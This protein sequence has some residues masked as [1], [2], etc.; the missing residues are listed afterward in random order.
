MHRVARL[1]LAAL[2]AQTA[3]GFILPQR[4]FSGGLQLGA[5]L[6]SQTAARDLGVQ[7]FDHDSTIRTAYDEWRG[8]FGKGAFD[9]ERFEKFKQN[10]KTLTVANLEAI[11]KAVAEGTNAPGWMYLNEFGDFSQ[12]EYDALT[13]ES[14]VDTYKIYEDWCNE[15]GVK[16]DANR[17]GVFLANYKSMKSYAKQTG[18]SLKLNKFADWTKAEAE[19]GKKQEPATQPQSVQPAQSV[20]AAPI[21][22]KEMKEFI[23][24][25]GTR[26]LQYANGVSSLERTTTAPRSTLAI[27]SAGSATVGGAQ[28]A[29]GTRRVQSAGGS[30]QYSSTQSSTSDANQSFQGTRRI[31]AVSGTGRGTRVV[32]AGAVAANQSFQGTRAIQ[33]GT[34]N[35]SF[36]GTS[37]NP[38]ANGMAQGTRAIQPANGH[39]PFQGT[40]AIQPTAPYGANQQFEGTRAIE[41]TNGNQSIQGT[42]QISSINGASAPTGGES[43]KGT[44][45]IP[46]IQQQR[47]FRGTI[48]LNQPPKDA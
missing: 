10:F 11:N 29:H 39:Q 31:T 37:Q 44:R 36:Q 16:A 1:V 43:F 47:P 40:R 18:K 14:D 30:Q 45:R 23:Q 8:E 33:P 12:A 9:D 21:A 15:F 6:S 24:Q 26:I 32:Q 41:P 17:Y 38:P 13:I 4:H 7:I 22:D 28:P 5:V 2:A 20:T 34:P 25:R 27:G 42:R 19:D 46:D 48:A 35:Q 3:T